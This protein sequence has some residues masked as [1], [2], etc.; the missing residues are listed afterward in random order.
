[1]LLMGDEVRRSQ[2]GN[3]NTYCLDDPQN[4]FDWSLVER[5]AGLR[6]FVGQLAA[7]RQ[8]PNVVDDSTR[9]TLNQLLQWAHIEWHGVALGRPDWS[10]HSHSLAFTAGTPRW[11]FVLHAMF[12]AYCEPLTFEVP[13]GGAR[14]YGWQR[15]VDTALSSP[16]DFR[17]LDEAPP[18]VDGSY[19]VQPRSCVVLASPWA[20][21]EAAI[22]AEE[23]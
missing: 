4:W 19:C 2:N 17:T 12:N 13:R 16:D 3:N 7:F 23:Q 18:V 5:H 8:G 1:M 6:R 9:Y 14:P 15:C 11:P 22:M 20:P 21:A 10:D